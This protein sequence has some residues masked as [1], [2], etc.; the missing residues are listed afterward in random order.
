MDKKKIVE[1]YRSKTWH[2][3]REIER[4]VACLR[5]AKGREHCTVNDTD[6]TF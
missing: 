3:F 5:L 1:E 4:Y 2:T 6:Q